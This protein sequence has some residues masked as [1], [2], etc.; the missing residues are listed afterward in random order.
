MP[1]DTALIYCERYFT[2]GE[3]FGYVD[4]DRDKEPMRRAF[5][6]YLEHVERALG[7]KGRLLDVGCATGYFLEIARNSGWEAEGIDISEHAASLGR[8]K[9]LTVH[10]GLLPH[11]ALHEGSFDAITLFD[12]IEHVP[13]P[14]R[15]LEE[16][17]R[18]LR[19]GGIFAITSPDAGSFW[20]RV[21]G[22]RWHAVVPPEHIVL[23]NRE[24]LSS[25]L[26][27]VG[28]TPLTTTTIGKHFTLPYIFQTL[29]HWQGLALWRALARA[30]NTGLLSRFPIPI[31]FRDTFFIMVRKA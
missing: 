1:S 8:A 21:M 26:R 17:R 28:Y 5:L 14:R 6:L 27:R 10:T 11:P 23:F 12:V 15:V 3:A 4:Y 30:T 29:A 19:K 31:N 16:C 22:Q 7:R 20:A 13:E 25:L 2:G 18:L 24:N 9:G